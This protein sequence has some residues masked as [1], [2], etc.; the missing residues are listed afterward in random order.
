MDNESLKQP[1]NF[2]LM[3]LIQLLRRENILSNLLLFVMSTRYDSGDYLNES[4]K[5]NAIWVEWSRR[6]PTV[7]PVLGWE[8][9]SAKQIASQPAWGS[10]AQWWFVEVEK[11][12]RQVAEPLLD[13]ERTLETR[14]SLS[15]VIIFVDWVGSHLALDPLETAK[16]FLFLTRCFSHQAGSE[17]WLIQEWQE[18][19][20]LLVYW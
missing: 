7:Q 6:W 3:Y 18:K 4:I 19:V 20:C 5:R 14:V 13:E 11:R 15:T 12:R 2:W 16:S 17:R 8:G 9:C 10:R 1:N